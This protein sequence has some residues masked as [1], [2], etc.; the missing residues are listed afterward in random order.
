MLFAI[1]VFIG[2]LFSEITYPLFADIDLVLI[3]SVSC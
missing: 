3:H 1:T 2:L